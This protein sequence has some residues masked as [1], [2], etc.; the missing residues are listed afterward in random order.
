MET[1][2]TETENGGIRIKAEEYCP[3]KDDLKREY[4]YYLAHRM[5]D[6][7]LRK[8]LIS[9]GEFNNLERKFRAKF[10]PHLAS[11]MAEIAG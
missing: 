9:L 2:I 11:V 1:R 6:S 7:L 3:T 5:I 10:S 4:N 8:Q